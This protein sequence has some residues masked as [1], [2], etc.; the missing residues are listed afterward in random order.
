MNIRNLKVAVRHDKEKIQKEL[1][2]VQEDKAKRKE[3]MA[4]LA[5]PRPAQLADMTGLSEKITNR[6]EAS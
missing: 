6:K 4:L 1:D 2:V 3:Y 5:R